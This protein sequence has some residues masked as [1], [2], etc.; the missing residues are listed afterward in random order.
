[1]ENTR[2]CPVFLT[3]LLKTYSASH[4]R[5]TLNSKKKNSKNNW[6]LILNKNGPEFF[7]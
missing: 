6:K 3:K 7:P 1:M 4:C 2:Q 5:I